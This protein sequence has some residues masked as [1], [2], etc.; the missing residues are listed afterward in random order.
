MNEPRRGVEENMHLLHRLK[1]AMPAM[2]SL[3]GLLIS[4]SVYAEEA[5]P[6][7]G[8]EAV[9]FMGDWL[10]RLVNFAII[11]GVVVYFLRK[12]TRDFFRNRTAEIAGAMRES[13]EAR[14]RA[15]AALAELEQKLG[16]LRGEMDGMLADAQT[17]GE[18]D[19]QALLEEGKRAADDIKSQVRQGIDLEVRKARTALA[20]EAA[21]LSVDLAEGK[22]KA[23]INKADQDRMV[24]EYIGKTGGWG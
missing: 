16:A 21:A 8:R 2:S 7:G 1:K 19:K 13:K 24:R 5:A 14:E 6:E 23:T 12:P 22:L 18:K 15:V 10:P 11:A 20:A 3:A 9:T 4:V 17:R